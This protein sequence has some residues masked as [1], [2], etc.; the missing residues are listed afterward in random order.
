MNI[1]FIGHVDSGKSSL[2]GRI[3]V[4]TGVIDKMALNKYKQEAIK[5]GRENWLY[6]YIMDTSEEERS[7][8][9]TKEIGLAYFKTKT[10]EYTIID[11]PG[12]KTYVKEMLCGTALA[13]IGI[14]LV[15]SKINEFKAGFEGGQTKEHI[16]NLKTLGIEKI[17][18]CINKMDAELKEGNW[19]QERY[20]VII[21]KLRPFLKEVGFIIN[22]NVFFIPISAF[23][24]IN[25]V[26]LDNT[27][28]KNKN[29]EGK[30]IGYKSLLETLDFL[31]D[32]QKENQKE[33][34]KE[35]EIIF[36]VSTT[37]C[38]D[39][40]FILTGKLIKGQIS[41]TDKLFIYS[42]QLPIN[43]QK[44]QYR[45]E[46]VDIIYKNAIADLY[47]NEDSFKY[48]S[49]GET[50]ISKKKEEEEEIKETE[51]LCKIKFT[52]PK[53][54]GLIC[55][56]GLELIFHLLTMEE[57][58]II[59]EIFENGKKIQV[60]TN[61][62]KSYDVV[63]YIKK[64]IFCTKNAQFILRNFDDTIGNGIILKRKK[65]SSLSSDN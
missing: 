64:N 63:L 39:K 35:D 7:S 55:T 59:K 12:H 34:K 40:N 23:N 44:I 6:A 38:Y 62:E 1:I 18:I 60:I 58:C 56:K 57:S 3:L 27:T 2:S 50:I 19:D 13:D 8:A 28:I 14:L 32:I 24:G 43:I 54:K 21:N 47:I 65:K 46:E 49:K 11:S 48:I 20:D 53:E 17:I 30:D 10:N 25:I 41:Q 42:N 15:S 9:I 5:N 31:S 33:E 29:K 51:I 45:N 61:Y 52:D 16:K 22:K 26:K 37:F 36:I 4:D